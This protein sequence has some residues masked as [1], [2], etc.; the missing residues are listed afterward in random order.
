[1]P[2]QLATQ[3][4]PEPD[5]APFWCSVVFA[6][7]NAHNDRCNKIGLHLLTEGAYQELAAYMKAYGK[8]WPKNIAP[9][10]TGPMLCATHYKLANEFINGE[11]M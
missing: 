3:S 7:Y 2:E 11:L 6:P 5:G 8:R 9:E 1:M 10:F 4:L